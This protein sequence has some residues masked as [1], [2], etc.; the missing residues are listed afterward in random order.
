MDK[1]VWQ[2]SYKVQCCSINNWTT[3]NGKERTKENKGLL[4]AIVRMHG[5]MDQ[6]VLGLKEIVQE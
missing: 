5:F 1:L 4:H 2:L 6:W 3:P